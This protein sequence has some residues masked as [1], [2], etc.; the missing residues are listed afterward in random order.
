M[1]EYDVFRDELRTW[2]SVTSL[3]AGGGA[4]PVMIIDVLLDLA[5]LSAN[6]VLVLNEANGRRSRVRTVQNPRFL[7]GDPAPR[8]APRGADG[9]RSPRRPNLLLERWTV[10]LSPPAPP[11]PPELPGV[12]KQC[13]SLFRALYSLSRALPAHALYRLLRRRGGI[14]NGLKMGCRM[15][16]GEEESEG[17]RQGELG[18]GQSGE[19]ALP[20]Y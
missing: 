3:T 16:T 18:F 4:I 20:T 5:D 6:Q 13:I 8:G 12:Y 17:G 2:R 10:E 19:R 9:G 11:V 7:A 14:G 1:E 15:S